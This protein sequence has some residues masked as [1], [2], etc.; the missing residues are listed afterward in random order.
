MNKKIIAILLTS[1]MLMQLSVS[2][3]Q[4]DT[5]QF[6]N[7][8][9]LYQLAKQSNIKYTLLDE[10][11]RRAAD[12]YDTAKRLSTAIS[13]DISKHEDVSFEQRVVMALNPLTTQK[14]YLD[15][16]YEFMQLQN[17]LKTDATKNYFELFILSEDKKL[18]EEYYKYMEKKNK[19]K[20]V[21]LSLGLI[22]ELDKQVFEQE[23]NQSYVKYLQAS[24]AYA[25]KKRNVNL[26]IDRDIDEE[27]NLLDVKIPEFKFVEINLDEMVGKVI[28]SSYR[29]KSLELQ[30]QIAVEEKKSKSRFK[31]FG[32]KQI[33]IDILN[34]R[35]KELKARINDEKRLIKR[36]LYTYYQNAKIAMK[37]TESSR[38]QKDIAKKNY[39]IA[40]IKFDNGMISVFKLHEMQN[41]Y[42]VA[43]Y[44]AL[45][46]ELDEYIK[47]KQCYDF[48][49]E[50]T[51][52]ITK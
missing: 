43:Y 2:F 49:D 15:K 47:I 35:I 22:T 24:S 3:G 23:F 7:L 52:D 28:D 38:I 41:A 45:K 12:K 26:F 32:E 31:G 51:V 39:D 13:D 5:K 10:Q 44:N 8:N 20:E 27:L 37:T 34:D 40:K 48:I 6:M 46:S 9:S 50:N 19:S 42:E 4:A 11:L 14:D 25:D 16:R 30:Q 33:E 29:I 18:K 17:T 36:D 21:E 1:C